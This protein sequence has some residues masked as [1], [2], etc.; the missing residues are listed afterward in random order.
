MGTHAIFCHCFSTFIFPS[1]HSFS[2]SVISF[3][4]ST[5]THVGHKRKA[6]DERD[7]IYAGDDSNAG[8]Y[9]RRKQMGPMGTPSI[10]FCPFYSPLLFLSFFFFSSYLFFSGV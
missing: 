7:G 6:S 4:T 2:Y 10:I 1:F 3:P 8:R 5:T 9:L